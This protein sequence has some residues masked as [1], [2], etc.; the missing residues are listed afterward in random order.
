MGE[1]FK[2]EVEQGSAIGTAVEAEETNSVSEESKEES[3]SDES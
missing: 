2:S 3:A 1:P